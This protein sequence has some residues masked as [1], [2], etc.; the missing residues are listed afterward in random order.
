MQ[1][2]RSV[3]IKLAYGK[4]GLDVDLPDDIR[5]TAIVPAVSRIILALTAVDAGSP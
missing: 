4:R 3:R 1:V 2:G 5:V